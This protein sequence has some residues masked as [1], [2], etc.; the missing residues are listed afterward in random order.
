VYRLKSMRPVVAL[1]V[2]LSILSACVTAPGSDPV[3]VKTQQSLKTADAI[4]SEAMAYYFKPGVAATLGRDGVAVFE[5]IRTGYDKPY[6]GVQAA[7]DAYKA[8]RSGDLAGAVQALAVIINAALP[9]L[10]KPALK[11]VEVP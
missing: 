3:V 4:Y 2:T 8:G 1:L 10:A 6:K 7:L 11:P 5:R 9:Y